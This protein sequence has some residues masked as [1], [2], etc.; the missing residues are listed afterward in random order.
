MK[1]FAGCGDQLQDTFAVEKE[2]SAT[3]KK[4]KF[5][6][7]IGCFR[8]AR[9]SPIVRQERTSPEEKI[10]PRLIRKDFRR[11]HDGWR[12]VADVVVLLADL[13]TCLDPVRPV[14]D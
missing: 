10:R 2:H 1:V 13:P 7:G 12:D 9:P 14:D 11:F 5:Y 6:E 8:P 4:R 3:R